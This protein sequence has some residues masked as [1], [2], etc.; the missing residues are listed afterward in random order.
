MEIPLTQAQE[1]ELFKIAN[2]E[3]KEIA[4]VVMESIYARLPSDEYFL[5][6]LDRSIAQAD[7][8]EFI[9]EEEMDE[10]I[11]KLLAE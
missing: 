1:Q 10:R 6:K 5:A 3:G 4:D 11:A 8:G 9:E 2:D 7:R